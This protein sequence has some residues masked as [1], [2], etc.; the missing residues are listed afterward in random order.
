MDSWHGMVK[1]TIAKISS[2]RTYNV[3]PR[4]RLFEHIDK[5]RECPL[6]WISAPPGAGK[7]T[8]VASYLSQFKHPFLWLQIDDCDNDVANLFHYMKLAIKKI[9]PRSY[10]SLPELTPEYTQGMSTFSR[11][12]FRQLFSMINEPCVLVLDNYQDVVDNAD[13]H[14]MLTIGFEEIPEHVNVIIMSRTNPPPVYSKFVVNRLLCQ[15]NETALQLNTDEAKGLVATLN[16]NIKHEQINCYCEKVNGWVAGFILFLEHK[17][18]D[19]KIEGLS[20]TGNHTAL[21]DYFMTEVFEHTDSVTQEFLIKTSLLPSSIPVVVAEKF[22]GIAKSKQILVELERKHYFTQR[23]DQKT[24]TFRYHPLFKEFLQSHC[25]DVYAD[26]ILQKFHTQAAKLMQDEYLDVDALVLYLRAKDWQAAINILLKQAP[27]LMRQGRFHTL[28]RL[29]PQF[30]DY[31]SCNMPWLQYW[32]GQAYLNVNPASAKQ[33]FESAFSQFNSKYEES[34]LLLAWCGI[35]NTIIYR[36]STYQEMDKWYVWFKRH[37]DINSEFPSQFIKAQ[38]ASSL[39]GIYTYRF[40]G[41]IQACNWVDCALSLCEQI[42]DTQI[43]LQSRSLSMVYYGFVGE[44]QKL[45]FCNE[46]LGRLSNQAESSPLLYVAWLWMDAATPLLL[47]EP[48]PTLEKV[49]VGLKV[50]GQLGIRHWDNQFYMHAIL[51]AL[52]TNQTVI[53]SEYVDKMKITVDPMKPLVSSSF[54]FLSAYYLLKIEQPEK[55]LIEAEIAVQKAEASGSPFPIFYCH[56]VLYCVYLRRG[57]LKEAKIFLLSCNN[58]RNDLQSPFADYAYFFSA[59]WLS[60]LEQDD[61]SLN[62]NL[63]EM[64]RIGQQ[65]DIF[66]SWLWFPDIMAILCA[67]ALLNSIKPGYVIRLIRKHSIVPDKSCV[68]LDNWPYLI[69]L[70]TLGR[71]SLIIDDKPV[72]FAGKAQ[73]KPL[74]LLKALIAFGGR[75]VS[76][77]KLSVALWPDAAGDSAYQSFSMA[78]KRLREIIKHKN[79]L[80]LSEG[81]LTL[82][83]RYAWVDVWQLESQLNKMANFNDKKLSKQGP[84]L[85]NSIVN[86]YHGSF[87]LNEIDFNWALSLRERI[88]SKLIRQILRLGHE[89]CI[90]FNYQAAL[91]LYQRGLELDDLSEPLYQGI[92]SCCLAMDRFADGL[93]AY[94]RCRLAFNK[95]L[96]TTPSADTEKLRKCLQQIV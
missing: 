48:V 71:F 15:I 90:E 28:L 63:C 9:A 77:E 29:L 33:K 32:H 23:L 51:A 10:K 56:L 75:E 94:Q 1:T 16:I 7:T 4:S 2:P 26:G 67:K 80:V 57:E 66:A 83:N 76:V 8:L 3:Y 41:D 64:M 13:L 72:T 95:V 53:A 78:L 43:V 21:F 36:R 12:Y 85:L 24:L 73:K 70:H 37:Y 54:H 42:N 68:T 45:Q 69:K 82:D 65:N 22:T 93:C 47:G 19:P 87:L 6:V 25:R 79:V 40:P 61:L 35:V 62:V 58:L 39:V 38:V 50:A 31:I 30:P 34:G 18:T 5:A 14:T 27:V 11:N 59:S 86:S 84:R 74:E 81:K 52:H 44:L 46:S 88:H 96:R 92:M 17:D 20:E 89:Y 49:K 91:T 60:L 55:A